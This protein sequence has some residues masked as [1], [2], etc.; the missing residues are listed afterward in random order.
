MSSKIRELKRQVSYWRTI[1][2][3]A[4]K[5]HAEEQETK[6]IKLREAEQRLADLEEE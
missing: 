6:R 2:E 5:K 4:D 3:R 1:I